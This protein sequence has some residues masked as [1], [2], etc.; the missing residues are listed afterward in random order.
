MLLEIAMLG[1][2][3][4]WLLSSGRGMAATTTNEGRARFNGWHF[5]KPGGYHRE[6][7]TQP[8]PAHFKLRLSDAIPVLTRTTPVGGSM[9]ISCIG[10]IGMST[11]HFLL[12]QGNFFNSAQELTVTRTALYYCSQVATCRNEN[13]DC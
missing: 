11:S 1:P 3:S 6:K 8:Q 2:S 9:R 12:V 5:V 10:L 4:S 13:G 7:P